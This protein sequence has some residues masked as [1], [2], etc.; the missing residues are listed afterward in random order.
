MVYQTVTSWTLDFWAR[1][2]LGLT[3]EWSHIRSGV[4]WMS[5]GNSAWRDLAPMAGVQHLPFSGSDHLPLL[6][7]L[8]G[9]SHTGARCKN[10]RWRF[11]AHWIRKGECEKVVREGWESA[12][13]PHCFHRI[14]NGI[15]ACK[16]GLRQWSRNIHNNPRRTIEVLC[17]KLHALSLAPQ[18]EQAKS[19]VVAL[20][21]KLEKVYLDEDIFW[22][23]RNKVTWAQD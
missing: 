4:G 6:L 20:R 23:Q 3:N 1:L 15:E 22:R 16:L 8:I 7:R 10:R 18:M 17:D 2:L 21:A 13:D 19:E 12:L 5:C 11:N 9:Q 14:F